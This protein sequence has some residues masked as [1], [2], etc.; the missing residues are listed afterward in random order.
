[1]S[2]GSKK[3]EHRGGRK[4]GTPNKKTLD[5]FAQCDAMNI[6]PFDELLKIAADDMIKTDLRL[7]ALKEVASY[8]YPKRK[9]VEI[10]NEED[11]GFVV[12]IKDYVSS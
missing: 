11:K 9:S 10:S 4:A 3:G 8:L 1:M 2:R 12:V 6:N 7:Q 5:L